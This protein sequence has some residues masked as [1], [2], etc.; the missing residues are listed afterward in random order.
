M[1]VS[2][3]VLPDA[4]VLVLVGQVLPVAGVVVERADGVRVGAEEV[5]RNICS[6]CV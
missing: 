3:F 4:D 1:I 6:L 5:L 2:I